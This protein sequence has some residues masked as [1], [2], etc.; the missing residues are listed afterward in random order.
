MGIDF[1]LRMFKHLA[2]GHYYQNSHVFP[3][4]S[5]CDVKFPSIYGREKGQ[6]YSFE[7]VMT[8][9]IFF[10]L[11]FTFIWFILVSSL[12]LDILNFFN[13]CNLLCG[14]KTKMEMISKVIDDSILSSQNQKIRSSGN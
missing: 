4:Y 8:R 1:A 5:V 11:F 7:C 12:I 3:L 9:N 6:A 13:W 2:H 10:D 14:Y